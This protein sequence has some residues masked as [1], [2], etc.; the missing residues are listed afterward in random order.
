M[1]LPEYP[2]MYVVEDGRRVL[3]H[4][5]TILRKT[6]RATGQKEEQRPTPEYFAEANL[7]IT[8]LVYQ[9]ERAPTTGK[10][11]YQ[12]YME[13]EEPVRGVKLSKRFPDFFWQPADASRTQNIAYVTKIDSRVAGPYFYP[14]DAPQLAHI[15][16][17]P[18]PVVTE[19]EGI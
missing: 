1:S 2:P 18:A 6:W 9:D 7:P 16:P 8:F 19:P 5:A 12:C 14:A 3:S 4:W 17:A 15:L 11:H 13:F 10:L